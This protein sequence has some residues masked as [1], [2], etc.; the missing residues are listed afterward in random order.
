LLFRAFY[1][2]GPT[3]NR[4]YGYNRVGPQ[5]PI[6]FLL[7]EGTS[8]DPADLM[9]GMRLN[10]ACLRPLGGFS[11]WE[12]SAEIRYRFAQN[13]IVVAFVDASDV[14]T[15]LAHFNLN[16]PHVSVGP[17]LRYVSP[18]GPIRIDIGIPIPGLQA[19]GDNPDEPPDI[20]QV[21]P[22]VGTEERPNR[23]WHSYFALQILIGEAF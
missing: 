3:S 1:S 18:V 13:W 15:R 12:A 6:G 16:E 7:P 17:G 21:P 23:K 20:S 10:G 8:C 2:G 9:P 4:G 22:Y 5:G 19:N 14:S 11:L